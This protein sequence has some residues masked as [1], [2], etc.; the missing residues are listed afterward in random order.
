MGIQSGSGR[1]R[2]WLCRP[3]FRKSRIYANDRC[4]NDVEMVDMCVIG[5]AERLTVR[6]EK[7]VYS[8]QSFVQHIPRP[9]EGQTHGLLIFKHLRGHQKDSLLL[10]QAE[11]EVGGCAWPVVFQIGEGSPLRLDQGQPIVNR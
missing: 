8:R 10:Q 7:C 11:A 2:R 1:P 4:V 3:E 9:A 5:K 6:L